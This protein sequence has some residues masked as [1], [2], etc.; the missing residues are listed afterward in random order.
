M[1]E[2][3]GLYADALARRSAKRLARRDRLWQYYD[4]EHARLHG[5]LAEA[6]GP[7]YR[8]LAQI[9]SVRFSDN[10]SINLSVSV[11]AAQQHAAF[12]AL[13]GRRLGW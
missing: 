1:T 8:R 10:P 12:A 9:E 7:E 6:A 13:S 5:E 11:Q 3:E 2:N 4:E